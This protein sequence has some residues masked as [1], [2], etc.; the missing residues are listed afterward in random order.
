MKK[1]IKFIL[2]VALVIAI[3]PTKAEASGAYR[4]TTIKVNLREKPKGK[5][6]YKVSRNTRVKLIKEG[7]T[8]ARVSYKGQRLSVVKK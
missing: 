5:I 7:K 4:Y 2:I 6:V 3:L 8:W 1:I